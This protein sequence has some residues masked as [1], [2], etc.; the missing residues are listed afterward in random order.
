MTPWEPSSESSDKNSECQEEG[1]GEVLP[2]GEHRGQGSG[3]D[4]APRVARCSAHSQFRVSQAVHVGDIRRQFV[5]NWGLF[6]FWL[7]LLFL[8]SV[9][10]RL[11]CKKLRGGGG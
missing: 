3:G 1:L 6:L 10:F 2:R 4:M 7:L 11:Q 5:L 9:D 8:Q